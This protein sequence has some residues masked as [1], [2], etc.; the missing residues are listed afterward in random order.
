[1]RIN[2][3][4]CAECVSIAFVVLHGWQS[5]RG[6]LGWPRL[7]SRRACVLGLGLTIGLLSG[8]AGVQASSS[9]HAPEV[10]PL[11]SP[12]WPLESA[13]PVALDVRPERQQSAPRPGAPGAPPRAKPSAARGA[14]E[15]A[16]AQSGETKDHAAGESSASRPRFTPLEPE[17]A[18]RCLALAWHARTGREIRADSLAVL[19]S[20]WALETARGE[21]MVE[22]NFGGVKGESPSGHSVRLWTRELKQG[23]V[24]RALRRFRSYATP[25][26]GAKDYLDLL[27]QRYRGAYRAM[28]RGLPGEFVR[29]LEQ[30]GYFTD[31]AGA[32]RR[33]MQ[34]LWREFVPLA[35][36]LESDPVDV[37]ARACRRPAGSSPGR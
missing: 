20:H 3:P 4:S 15:R 37:S 23:R 10:E 5:A 12:L 26:E 14:A 30:R 29:V 27:A 11:G 19:L 9:P 33:A 8:E 13:G 7:A 36:Q 35:R 34:R 2:W 28:I 31:H 32:Y 21:R 16:H 18:G 24:V 1:M 17:T 6:G 25:E 22:H